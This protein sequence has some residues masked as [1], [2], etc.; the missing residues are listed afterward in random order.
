MRARLGKHSCMSSTFFIAILNG[1]C[2][3][4]DSAP[5]CSQETFETD[6]F[7]GW[8]LCN[9]LLL[10]SSSK[11]CGPQRDCRSELQLGRCDYFFSCLLSSFYFNSFLLAFFLYFFVAF[12]PYYSHAQVFRRTLMHEFYIFYDHTV[13]NLLFLLSWDHPRFGSGELLYYYGGLN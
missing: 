2:S 8:R 6:G 11:S 4:F 9:F 10:L 5:T 12:Q 3:F 1:I 7:V 13:F